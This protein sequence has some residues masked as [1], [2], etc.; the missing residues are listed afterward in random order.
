MALVDEIF[1]NLRAF[2]KAMYSTWIFYRPAHVVFDAGEG[3]ATTLGNFVFAVE[4]VFLSHGHYDHVGG[5]AGF[6]LA[7]A[8]AMGEKTKPLAIHY[9]AGD[10][11]V[12]QARDYARRISREL[13][14]PLTWHPIGPGATIPLA[15]GNGA[16]QIRAFPTRHIRG[17][18]T[19][20][21]ALEESRRRLR[22]ALAGL[23]GPELGRIRR[24]QGP[25][26]V[27]E[28]YRKI[29]LAYSGDAMPLDP[30][31]VKDALVLL[32]DATFLEVADRETPTHATV[33]EALDVAK[34]A[35]VEHLCLY[36][37]STRYRRKAIEQGI[38]DQA[39]AHGCTMPLWLLHLG[40]L[41]RLAE[42]GD[43]AAADRVA[44]APAL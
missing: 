44:G 5:I 40:R 28:E 41:E 19:L 2:S 21:F 23:P 20:G 22:P 15:S 13:T 25:D 36:H 6:I 43:P 24:E 39:K 8:A 32:H 26:A 16:W 12:E 34:A 1:G 4:N 18:T 31:H 33:G 29:L 3:L 27:T 11:L 37:V 9:P 42:T 17:Q 38:R 10:G 7:R 14:Y 35:Q 30:A